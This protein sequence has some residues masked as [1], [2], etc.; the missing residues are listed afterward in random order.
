MSL[1]NEQELFAKH[2]SLLIT[3][4]VALGFGVRIGEVFRP[5]EMQEIYVKTGR[6]KT[7][8]SMHIKKCA[9]DLFLIKN[10]QIATRAQTQ[11][12]GDWWEALDPKNQWGGNWKSFVDVPHFQRTV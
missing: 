8:N 10:G 12:L 7:M 4:A 9:I 6:S 5:P 3:K 1:G 11:E 2:V